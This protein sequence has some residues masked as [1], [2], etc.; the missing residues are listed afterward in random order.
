VASL[1]AQPEPAPPPPALDY[2]RDLINFRPPVAIQAGV[3]ARITWYGQAMSVHH[4]EDAYGPINLDYY[5]VTVSSLPQLFASPMD[6]LRHIRTRIN[7]FVDTQIAE[8]TPYDPAYDAA[9]WDP[10]AYGLPMLGAVIHIDMKENVDLWGSA[11]VDDG[12]VVVA[13]AGP[14]YWTFSTIWTPDDFAHLVSGNRQFGFVSN[15]DGS[16]TFF[17]RGADRCTSR[18]DNF[19]QDTVFSAGHALWVSFQQR[20]EAY[21]VDHGGSA[22]RGSWLSSRYEWDG[23]YGVASY[24][25]A[26]DNVWTPWV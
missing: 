2:W 13:D 3:K 9:L 23:P 8:F 15:V 21:V 11:N 5:P 24:Y 20:I 17:T 16:Y 19:L 22:S 1:V 26:P 4:I 6:L 18:V 7:D 14:S 25:F 12:S 10:G